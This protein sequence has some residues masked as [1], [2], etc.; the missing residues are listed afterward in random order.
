VRGLE[1]LATTMFNKPV[2]ELSTLD[3][4]DLIDALKAIKAGEV[5]LADALTCA[6]S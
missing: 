1:T 6:E 4:S 5:K 2:A 3:G